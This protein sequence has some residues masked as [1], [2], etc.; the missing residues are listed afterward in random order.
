MVQTHEQ[1]QANAATIR[2]RVEELQQELGIKFPVYLMFTKCD[3]VAGFS[4]FFANLSQAEREQVWGTTF[5]SEFSGSQ[6][7]VEAFNARYDD[8]LERLNQRLLWRLQQERDLE[9]RMR[10]FTNG[11]IDVST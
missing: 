10:Q 4:E 9:K 1:R 3:L 5:S 7:A 2:K 6:Q 11:E 8:I